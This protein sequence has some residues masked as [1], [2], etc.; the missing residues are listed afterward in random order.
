M[1]A[2]HQTPSA[3]GLGQSNMDVIDSVEHPLVRSAGRRGTARGT[4]RESASG[5]ATGMARASGTA[6]ATASAT[7]SAIGATGSAT[8]AT[9]RPT[10]ARLTSA[11]ASATTGA[12]D[13][14]V[15]PLTGQG[16]AEL[17]RWAVMRGWGDEGWGWR[18][19]TGGKRTVCLC[20]CLACFCWS[21]PACMC[22]LCPCARF[23]DPAEGARMA[24]RRAAVYIFMKCRSR[25]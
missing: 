21:L 18:N 6:R 24:A 14:A 9:A 19:Q 12:G 5:N 23:Y 15:A 25:L 4:A 17:Q 10:T 22:L 8:A 7:A 3:A 2:S 1:R 16:R 20:C 11:S 13:G